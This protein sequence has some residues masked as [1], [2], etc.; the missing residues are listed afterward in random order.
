MKKNLL[1]ITSLIIFALLFAGCATTRS[2]NTGSEDTQTQEQ[3]KGKFSQGVE[4]VKDYFSNLKNSGSKGEYISAKGQSNNKDA[5]LAIEKSVQNLLDKIQSEYAYEGLTDVIMEKHQ[6][7]IETVANKSMLGSS[8]T[9]RILRSDIDDII[10]IEKDLLN[11]QITD[12]I[13]ATAPNASVASRL[14]AMEKAYAEAASSPYGDDAK[15]NIEG[16]IADTANGLQITASPDYIHTNY[17]DSFN[18]ALTVQDSEGVVPGELQIAVYD[19]NEKFIDRVIT[20]ENGIYFGVF[21]SAENIPVGE[22]TFTFKIALDGADIPDSVF[23]SI[24]K[25]GEMKVSVANARV[26]TS[27]KC[28]DELYSENLMDST[29][30]FFSSEALKM[31]LVTP[32]DTENFHIELELFNSA[33]NETAHGIF[34]TAVSGAFYVCD[35]EGLVMFTLETDEYKGSATTLEKSYEKAISKF[36]TA[37]NAGSFFTDALN[38]AIYKD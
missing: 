21:P 23:D 37:I 4:K 34:N 9:S 17:G 20:S 36:F 19:I 30:E 25:S 26:S 32:G 13:A 6:E 35:S 10:D 38:S 12:M 22:N 28:A 11:Q 31:Q 18:V 24:N 2:G 8:Y 27:L 7:K 16:M 29:R 5:D 33:E 15:A 3:E 1:L 14:S